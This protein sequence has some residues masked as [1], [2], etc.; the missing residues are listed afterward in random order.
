MRPT[1][2]ADLTVVRRHAADLEDPHGEGAYAR[3]RALAAYYRSEAARLA[4]SPDGPLARDMAQRADEIA[5]E[6]ADAMLR[7]PSG[8]LRVDMESRPS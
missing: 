6:I 5:E 4:W 3:W 1:A 2:E 7:R 8:H